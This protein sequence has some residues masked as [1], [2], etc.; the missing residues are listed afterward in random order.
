MD[1]SFVI[2]MITA[3]SLEVGEQISKTLLEQKLAACV[4]ILP[5]VQSFFR[6]EGQVSQEQEVLLVVKTRRELFEKQFIPAVKAVHPYDLP[7]IIAMPV[8]LGSQ[9][10]LDWIAQETRGSEPA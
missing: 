1:F 6:W 5:S 9:D 7:E 10:Y 3:P 2:A 8:V 4:N